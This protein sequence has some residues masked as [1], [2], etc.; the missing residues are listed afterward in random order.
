[1]GGGAWLVDIPS[2]HNGL[3]LHRRAAAGV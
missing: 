3:R 2:S 1:M